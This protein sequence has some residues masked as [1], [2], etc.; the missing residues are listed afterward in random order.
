M[1]VL[2]YWGVWL[3]ARADLQVCVSER[4]A[5]QRGVSH[6]C[7]ANNKGTMAQLLDGF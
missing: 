4:V 3:M 5:E 2:A 7:E 6:Y 1:T